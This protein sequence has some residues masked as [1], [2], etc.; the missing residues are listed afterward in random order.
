ML[1]NNDPYLKFIEESLIII[2]DKY[3][4]VFKY[5]IHKTYSGHSITLYNDDS[6]IYY[7]NF[8]NTDDGSHYKRI[9][10]DFFISSIEKTII[11]ID[12]NKRIAP[13]PKDKLKDSFITYTKS[14]W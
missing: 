5:E 8:D 3:K 2:T 6:I 12:N 7:R 13:K 10:L 1:D 9:C 4:S 14:R 11:Q